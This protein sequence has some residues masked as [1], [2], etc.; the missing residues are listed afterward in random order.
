MHSKQPVIKLGIEVR[1]GELRDFE[2]EDEQ[3]QNNRKD[4]IAER[5]D[6]YFAHDPAVMEG[7]HG[8]VPGGFALCFIP[9]PF[10]WQINSIA[11]Q[12]VELS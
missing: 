2:V 10:H 8:M 1:A 4:V 3:G 11:V 12:G 6:P 9:K 5:F 7:G